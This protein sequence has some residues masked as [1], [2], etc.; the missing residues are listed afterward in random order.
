MMIDDGALGA[1]SCS[2]SHYRNLK[3]VVRP[4][5]MSLAFAVVSHRTREMKYDHTPTNRRKEV[6]HRQQA[7]RSRRRRD[8]SAG[9]RE[10]YGYNH[11]KIPDGG[12]HIEDTP[13]PGDR[14]TDRNTPE[15]DELVIVARHLRIGAA[16]YTIDDLDGR[17]TVA[18]L[19][20][21]YDPAAPVL[22][23]VYVD[24]IP[25]EASDW[26][27]DKLGETIE[28]G[29]LRVYAFPADRLAY[30]GEAA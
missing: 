5:V 18:A 13:K 17:P 10:V 7:E 26:T 23:A 2:A 1:T 21:E 11:V 4:G 14:V 9:W 16:A 12:R 30:G 22:E 20:P 28:A 29:D 27:V 15:D 6:Q 3:N 19:N 8:A 24:D 25:D